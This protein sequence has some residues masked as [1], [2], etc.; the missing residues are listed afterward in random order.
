M[1][2]ADKKAVSSFQ[3][4]GVQMVYLYHD[5]KGME[6]ERHIILDALTKQKCI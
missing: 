3:E 4:T 1:G 6:P 5:T 2:E